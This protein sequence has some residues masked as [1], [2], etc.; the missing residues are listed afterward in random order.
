MDLGEPLEQAQ[1]Y[2]ARKH[3]REFGDNLVVKDN[4]FPP[5]YERKP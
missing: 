2:K 4:V 1:V 5:A 3:E